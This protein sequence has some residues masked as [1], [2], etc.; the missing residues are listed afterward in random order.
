MMDLMRVI[1]VGHGRYFNDYVLAELPDPS[2]RKSES[3]YRITPIAMHELDDGLFAM[4]ANA[5]LADEQGHSMSVHVT[6]GL[7]NVYLVQ[8]RGDNWQ[9]VRYFDNI[10]A[11]GSFGNIGEVKWVKLSDTK[12]GLAVL[13]GGTWQGYSIQAL[14]LYDL[15][16]RSMHNLLRESIPVMSTSEGAC[17]EETNEC[18]TVEGN[19]RFEQNMIGRYD[20][21][22]IDFSGFKEARPEGA[23]SNTPRTRA[24]VKASAR[25]E[26][27]NGAYSLVRGENI[28]PGI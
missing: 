18:W 10:D 13:H 8:K 14:A 1:F 16:D 12:H 27:A 25:Y 24:V 23:Q 5:E 11:L 28:V 6:P 9:L 22:V 19:W 17:V 4:V 7:L 21:L 15:T 20:D 2:D 26:Y 3:T